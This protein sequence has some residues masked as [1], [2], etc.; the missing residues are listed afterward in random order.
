MGDP[1]DRRAVERYPVN[2]DTKCT[3]LSPVLED[4]G[5]VRIKN[6]SSEGIGL[7]VG[8]KLEPG[9]L[10]AVTITNPTKPFNKT[11]MVRVM[12]VTEQAG[13]SYLVGG[14]FTTALAY[15]ELT[16]MVM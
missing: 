14:A 13:G 9:L 2:I 6:V 5:P 3:F 16:T 15:D 11:L 10:L 1:R 12:H 8:R 4:F 7:I